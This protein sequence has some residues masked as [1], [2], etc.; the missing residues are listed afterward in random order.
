MF[1]EYLNRALNI[2]AI[3]LLVVGLHLDCRCLYIGTLLVG[4]VE[5]STIL[6]IY[7]YYITHT[8]ATD[9]NY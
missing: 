8:R 2:I 3:A 6:C 4:M 5:Y 7:H 9:E 1:P